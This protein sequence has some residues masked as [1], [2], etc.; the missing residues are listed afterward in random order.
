MNSNLAVAASLPDICQQRI[1]QLL[2]SGGRKILGI[3]AAPGAG[4][5]TLAQAIQTQFGDAVQVVPMDGFHLS[6]SEL[7]RLGRRQ[8]K[9]APDTF[10]AAGY[11]NLLRRIQTQRGDEVVYAPEYRREVEEAIAGAIAVLPQTQLIITEGNYLL[12]E[13]DPWC[14]LS[15][16]LDETWFLDVPEDLRYSRLLARHMR[17]GRTEQQARDWITSTDA[18]NAV[19]ISQGRARADVHLPWF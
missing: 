11:V 16:V 8:R 15:E 12:L 1:S 14:Q 17:F 13:D 9:G 18:P 2:A 7:V 5:S 19:R 6:N 10:D 3:V 4:K